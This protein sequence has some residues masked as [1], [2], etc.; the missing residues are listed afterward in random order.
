M[1]FKRA[2]LLS[3]AGNILG[4]EQLDPLRAFH[5]GLLSQ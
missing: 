3:E 5:L 1:G 4:P 2:V